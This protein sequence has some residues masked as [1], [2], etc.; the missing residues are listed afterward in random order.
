MGY[1]M[2]SSGL[3]FKELGS[4][5]A[6]QDEE[7]FTG[8]RTGKNKMSIEEFNKKTEVRDGNTY[9]KPNE[10]DASNSTIDY[11][12]LSGAELQELREKKSKSE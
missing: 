10:E 3:P 5:P 8:E 6:K 9:D 1:T 11:S 7:I 12:K 4:S 2:K